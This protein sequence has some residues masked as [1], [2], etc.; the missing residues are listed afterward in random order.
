MRALRGVLGNRPITRLQLAFL[1]FNVAE[2]AMW[3]AILV[4]AFDRGST[5]AVGFV[6]ILLMV[7]LRFT[8]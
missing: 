7:P 8:T 4:Y 3:V 6:S 5:Q 1:L 2:P